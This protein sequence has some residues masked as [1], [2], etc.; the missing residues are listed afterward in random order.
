M[1]EKGQGNALTWALAISL[2]F[3]ILLTIYLLKWRLNI[4]NGQ[5]SIVPDELLK[6]LGNQKDSLIK[7]TK[8]LKN[9]VESS[10]YYQK[11][12]QQQLAELQKAFSIFQGSL[13]SKDQ[14][15]DRH[16][17]GYDFHVYK[18]FVNKFIKFYIDLKKEADAPENEHASE[19]L[20]DMLAL[21]EDALD[22]CN[23]EIITPDMNKN[24]EE[25]ASIISA[26]KKSQLTNDP[27]IV[28]KIAKIIHPA[29]GLRTSSG[30]DMLREASVSVYSIEQSEAA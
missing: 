18:N 19:L 4:P 23:V 22:E 1:S 27:K 28:G 2:C 13:D 17:K 3:S 25:Q 10:D 6:E 24:I 8:T 15:I 9:Y 30:I 14:E 20:N 11:S 29:F 5:V 16:K 7:N 26:N 21:F 12:T